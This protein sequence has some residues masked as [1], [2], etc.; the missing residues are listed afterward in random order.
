MNFRFPLEP[1]N[2]WTLLFSKPPPPVFQKGS[3]IPHVGRTPVPGLEARVELDS[4]VLAFLQGFSPETIAGECFRTLTLEQVYGAIAHY[5]AHRTEVDAY[6]RKT[7]A[8]WEAFCQ[9]V[10]GAVPEFTQRLT[11]ARRQTQTASP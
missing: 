2:P 3:K 4:V 7:D 9:A 10:H 11:A 1:S 6:L 5:L 8:G